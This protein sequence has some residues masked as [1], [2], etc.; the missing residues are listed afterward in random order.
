MD[1]LYP[2]NWSAS[3]HRV[4]R[5]RYAH[6]D[7]LTRAQSSHFPICRWCSY[8]HQ[9]QPAGVGH[10]LPHPRHFWT[11]LW[12]GHDPTKKAPSS[13]LT[14]GV[15]IDQ[16]ILRFLGQ[17]WSLPC[18]RDGSSGRVGG[19]PLQLPSIWSP[20]KASPKI[21]NVHNIISLCILWF[22][23]LI[24]V[25]NV[26]LLWCFNIILLQTIKYVFCE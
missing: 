4:A 12:A 26:I 5:T 11:G 20:T 21:W 6:G 7:W 13:Q 14:E 3:S 17:L 23:S 9:P 2:S 18:R 8:F 15:Y 16:I 1:A 24:D 25:F 22:L 10:R 19:A